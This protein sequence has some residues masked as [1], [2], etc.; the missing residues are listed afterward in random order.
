MKCVDTHH[1]GLALLRRKTHRQHSTKED[2]EGEEPRE[3]AELGLA[4]ASMITGLDK[5]A[6][7]RGTES[8]SPTLSPPLFFAAAESVESQNA[9]WSVEGAL[10]H[11]V[12]G[13]DSAATVVSENNAARGFA[14][15]QEGWANTH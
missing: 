3:R 11:A 14:D 6:E 1:K 15:E 7:G 9:V 13:S 10:R 5:R 8:R 2:R 12:G 4:A